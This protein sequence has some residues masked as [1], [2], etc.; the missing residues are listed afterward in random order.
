MPKPPSPKK[1]PAK[2]KGKRRPDDLPLEGAAEMDAPAADAR[3]DGGDENPADAGMES[4]DD[5]PV[6][7]STAE[8]AAAENGERNGGADTTSPAQRPEERSE[9]LE[10][11]FEEPRQPKGNFQGRPPQQQNR[12]DRTGQTAARA[13]IAIVGIAEIGANL[14]APAVWIVRRGN[15]VKI[16]AKR[17]RN[18]LRR[19]MTCRRPGRSTSRSCR[20]CRWA[21]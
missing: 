2:P 17:A 9:R 13:V 3:E 15:A 16:A 11:R 5:M 20:R 1:A 21:I 10:P 6:T 8:S 7:Q 14:P 19:R 18:A 12:P 4:T